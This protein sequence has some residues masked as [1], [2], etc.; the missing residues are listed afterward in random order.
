MYRTTVTIEDLLRV[1][2]VA[3][4]LSEQGTD[5]RARVRA[6]LGVVT[7]TPGEPFAQQALVAARAAL[8]REPTDVELDQAAAARFDRLAYQ[9]GYL[10]GVSGTVFQLDADYQRTLHAGS[11]G[12]GCPG[13]P[14]YDSDAWWSWAKPLFGTGWAKHRRP[15]RLV[16]DFF[17]EAFPGARTPLE[18]FPW[19]DLPNEAVGIDLLPDPRHRFGFSNAQREAFVCLVRLL[20]AAHGFPIDPRH[21][22]THS[23]C[24]PCERGA[25]LR[26]EPQPGGGHVH[27]VR[28]IHWDPPRKHWPHVAVVA[29][30]AG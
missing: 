22:T 28:G 8:G 19:R 6:P 23:L 5:N 4:G 14:V 3:R 2:V 16:Y 12:A 21:V 15:G 18:V 27:V 11:L 13:G 24:A 26:R 17:A 1:G 30:A 20:A 9:P 7:H 29:E 10:I 25:V